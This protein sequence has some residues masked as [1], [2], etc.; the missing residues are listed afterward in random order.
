MKTYVLM[1][2]LLYLPVLLVSKT[3]LDF[4]KSVWQSRKGCKH[5]KLA[6]TKI[7][8]LRELVNPTDQE[9]LFE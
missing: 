4:N 1:H 8:K 6:V 9:K 5:L 7:M 3:L 2:N